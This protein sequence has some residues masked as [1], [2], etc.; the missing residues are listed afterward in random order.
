MSIKQLQDSLQKVIGF[1]KK[2]NQELNEGDHEDKAELV[3]MLASMQKKLHEKIKAFCEHSGIS[4]DQLNEMAKDASALTSPQKELINSAQL[5]ISSLNKNVNKFLHGET[6][7]TGAK[8]TVE[9]KK[10]SKS[11]WKKS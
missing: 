9:K 7:A 11:N 10:K 5:E 6:A 8:K 2:I 3:K 4:E 1:I